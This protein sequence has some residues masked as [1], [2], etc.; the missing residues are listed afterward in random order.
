MMGR[1]GQ[2]TDKNVGPSD[3]PEECFCHEKASWTMDA[4]GVAFYF[5]YKLDP[6]DGYVVMTAWRIG[7]PQSG[8][9]TTAKFSKRGQRCSRK[10]G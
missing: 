5:T 6:G 2:L 10:D 8:R 4:S 3:E 1:N 9:E 7:V